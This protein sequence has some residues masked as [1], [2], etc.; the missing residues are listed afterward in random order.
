VAWYD[1][2]GKPR[3][4]TSIASTDRGYI[5]QYEDTATGLS[6]LNNRYHDPTLG[7]FLSVDPLV[8]STGEPY[9]YAGGN[10]T[11]LS[12]PTGLEAGSWCNNPD[13]SDQGSRGV[14][15]PRSPFGREGGGWNR[16]PLGSDELDRRLPAW[17]R[18]LNMLRMDALSMSGL[19]DQEI[20][21]AVQ[22][23]WVSG[24]RR[25]SFVAFNERSWVYS[26]P[27]VAGG[28]G[29]ENATQHM[30][31]AARLVV[32]YGD[33]G[34]AREVLNMHESILELEGELFLHAGWN[35][36][37]KMDI[38]NNE[39]G[40]AI[41]LDVLDR[42]GEEQTAC[43]MGTCGSSGGFAEADAVAYLEAQAQL[44][45]DNGQAVWRGMCAP[46]CVRYSSSDRP[47]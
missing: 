39:V 4:T 33:E 26:H 46:N 43:L 8:A 36:E 34:K 31:I 6:Y 5:G 29:T 24:H 7:V 41:G 38:I 20:S 15:A 23:Q 2:Y 13:C 42:W 14:S 28:P 40:I 44:A 11:T 10:P 17:T 9:I 25:M 37:R 45:I 19:E 27:A 35:D 12:D 16:P 21:G 30:F 22:D 18:D 3:G 1:P 32:A 47:S